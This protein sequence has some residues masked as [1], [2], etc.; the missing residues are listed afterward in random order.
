MGHPLVPACQTQAVIGQALMRRPGTVAKGIQFSGVLYSRGDGSGHT[1]SVPG[2]R[3][4]GR[5]V[6][7][8]LGAS[9]SST[10]RRRGTLGTV[11]SSVM[12]PV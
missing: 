1:G 9:P 6:L 11:P 5:R 3:C 7:V 2:C 8:H 4:R 10:G 12:R